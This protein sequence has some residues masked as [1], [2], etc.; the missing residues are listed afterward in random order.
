M[1]GSLFQ[2]N[3]FYHGTIRNL[4]TSVGQLFQ[5]IQIQKYDAQGQKQQVI[6]V[7]C[8]YG[9]KD[10]WLSMLKER[11]DYDHGVE[12]TLPRLAYEIID[13]RYD[14][15]RKIGTKGA[16]VVGNIADKRAKLFNPVPY[17]V[18][19]NVYSMC[20]D[21]NTSLQI[22]EQIL[23][24]FAPSLTISMEVLPVFNLMKDIPIVLSG[25]TVEDSYEGSPDQLRTV[26]QTFSL[27]AQLDLF[28]PVN[29]KSSIIK[30][31]NAG[32][33]TTP[34]VK[35]QTTYVADVVPETANKGDGTY[36]ITDDWMTNF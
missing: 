25:V 3:S 1:T 17:D 9:P 14:A 23:P 19:I 21:Q 27:V 33:T 2:D 6:R 10:K 22:L 30:H 32:V 26:V 4:I 13:Y 20:K 24:Y 16:Y 8:E 34:T 11:P 12:I 36:V 5:G 18:H 28:G 31:V 35:V 7:P 29:P 15:A